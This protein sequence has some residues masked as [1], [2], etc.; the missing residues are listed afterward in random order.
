M[1]PNS[2]DLTEPFILLFLSFSIT[3]FLTYQRFLHYCLCSETSTYFV[4]V[5]LASLNAK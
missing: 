2:T 5:I 4:Q 3:F 1:V